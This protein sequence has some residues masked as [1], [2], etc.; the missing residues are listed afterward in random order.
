MKFTHCI[1]ITLILCCV[2]ACTLTQKERLPASTSHIVNALYNTTETEISINQGSLLK[3][4][5]QKAENLI[6]LKKDAISTSVSAKEPIH[7]NLWMKI[8]HN[9]VFDVV[10]MPRLQKRINWYLKQPNYLLSVNK[11]AM[12]YLF[13]IVIS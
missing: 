6:P 11:R 12:P 8:S 1:F 7:N 10:P 2:N 4:K 9:L 13:H 5:Q 3:D